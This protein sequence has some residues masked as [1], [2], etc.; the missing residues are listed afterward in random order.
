MAVES[1]KLQLSEYWVAE[2]EKI[3]N[4]SDKTNKSTLKALE[5]I[6]NAMQCNP[7]N[8]KAWANKGFFLKHLGKNEL[9]L[10]CLERA[11]S[12]KRDYIPPWYNR[13]VI[14]GLMGKFDDAVNCYN[15]VLKLDPNNIYAKRDRE[16]LVQLV[17]K[18]D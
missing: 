16:A 6:D 4:S 9:A 15:E 7:L 18:K 11:I 8:H 5:Y 12:L 1:N 2:S 17:K 10:Q 14:F 3:W 13:G